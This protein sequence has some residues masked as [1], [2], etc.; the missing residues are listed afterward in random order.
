MRLAITAMALVAVAAAGLASA[1]V[2][3]SNGLVNDKLRL[4]GFNEV[5]AIS[6]QATG[7]FA[8]KE[9]SDGS[10]SYSLSYTG[11]EGTV[12][13][14]H[15]HFGQ[16]GVAG[17][18]M[19]WLCGTVTNPGPAGTPAC[20]MPDGTVSGT[21]TA[22]QVVGPAGQGVA[23]GELSEAV[24]AMR[25]G[26]AYANVHSTKVPSGELRAQFGKRDSDK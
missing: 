19:L 14:S 5:P 3:A 25:E 24:R 13:Q 7:R 20:P 11:L 6:T 4:E 10:L 23:A 16:Q 2:Q 9:E 26:V 22:A 1:T 21:L 8:I 18:I 17:G 15:I 12:T